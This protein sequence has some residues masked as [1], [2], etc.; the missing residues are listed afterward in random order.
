MHPPRCAPAPGESHLQENL[1]AMNIQGL[2]R[3]AALAIATAAPVASQAQMVLRDAIYLYDID[4]YNGTDSLELWSE[5]CDVTQ[6]V[7]DL[8]SGYIEFEKWEY[9]LA[10]DSSVVTAKYPDRI[11]AAAK[12]F[13]YMLFTPERQI[14]RFSF[15]GSD[16]TRGSHEVVGRGT[17]FGYCLSDN[18]NARI[19]VVDHKTCQI[20]YSTR[21]AS[22]NGPLS[23]CTPDVSDDSG[24]GGGGTDDTQP[25]DSGSGGHGAD[26]TQ[27]D[28]SGTSGSG[29]SGSP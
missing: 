12:M 28:D 7:L 4:F 5:D 25:D 15:T 13:S 19:Y 3:I 26:D 11:Q 20:T 24:S 2:A 16:D 18:A 9:N 8:D 14:R 10:D 17:L 23:G 22:L 1:N 6:M 29:S 21:N 27:P